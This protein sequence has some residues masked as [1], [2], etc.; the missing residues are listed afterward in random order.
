MPWLNSSR[1]KALIGA[2][3]CASCVTGAA[4]SGALARAEPPAAAGSAAAPSSSDGEFPE[5]V[6]TSDAGLASLRRS[7]NAASDVRRVI[8][9]YRQFI[10]YTK[11]PEI[12]AQ[13]RADLVVWE[14]RLQRGLVNFGG[15]WIEP[16]QVAALQAQATDQ[17]KQAIAALEQTRLADA[18]RDL[19][20]ALAID[21]NNPTAWYL[22]GLL[23]YRQDKFA[24]ARKAF[25]TAVAAAPG[26]GPTL[27]NLAATAWR[28]KQWNLALTTYDQAM[29]VLPLDRG[30][31]ANVAEAL[32]AFPENQRTSGLYRR[33]KR[34]YDEQFV[35][36]VPRM[37]Q[38]GLAPWGA[39]WISQ[40]QA[41]DIRA[42]QDKLQVEIDK[43]Q[44]DLD[45]AQRQ[46][47]SLDA[48]IAANDEDLRRYEGES[49][50]Y[51]TNGNL[52]Q[53]PLPQI[54][55]TLR[56]ANEQNRVQ[57]AALDTQL[58]QYKARIAELKATP[59]AGIPKFT[60]IQQLYAAAAAPG[61]FVPAAA[62]PQTVLTVPPASIPVQV[63]PGASV[64]PAAPVP[65]AATPPVTRPGAPVVVAPPVATPA[66]APGAQGGDL[67][68]TPP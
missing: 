64:S 21:P 53:F 63:T 1:L 15:R 28:L 50:R 61:I 22:R 36:L 2:A 58:R 5:F 32:E 25:E 62:V 40:K 57:R 16:G 65:P 35:Q 6:P 49:L 12:A 7:S 8:E 3:V 54:Y 9:R 14:D 11:S 30:L 34:R 55:Y 31:L 10:D 13:A 60:G 59:P 39:T 29:L 41:D 24:A 51:D 4:L 38:R 47:T 18:E 44:A 52:L 43:A 19:A 26:H 33:V 23:D 48:Q 20:A 66:V 37:A 67:M 27:S 45:A 56:N 46:A 42:A 68:P 17:A